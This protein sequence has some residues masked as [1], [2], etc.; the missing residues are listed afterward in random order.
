MDVLLAVWEGG[1]TIPPEMSIAARLV[2]RGHHVRV[3]G[4]PTVAQAATAA[5]AEHVAWTTAP[6]RTSM[7]PADDL[8][9]D[10]QIKSPLARFE[11]ALDVLYCGP[12][13]RY[14]A[15]VLAEVDRRRPDVALIDASLFG[16]MVAVEARGVPFSVLVPNIHV[17]PLPGVPPI[18]PGWQPAR[19]P[20]G[21][22]R[23]SIFAAISNGMWNRAVKPLNVLRARLGLSAVSSPWE[24]FD[25]ADA[26]HVLTARAFEFPAARLPANLRYVGPQLADPVWAEPWTSP[27]PA[28]DTRP[29]V[30]VGL[31]STYQAQTALLRRLVAVLSM[32]PV[33]ALVTLGPS[34]STSAVTSRSANV[35]VVASAPH[36]QIL[37]HASLAITHG[38]HGTTLKALAAGVPL[39]CIP[40]GR[41]QP[42]TAARVTA[43]GAGVRLPKTA[44]ERRL[45]RA[46]ERVL[47][48]PSIRAAARALAAA[49]AKESAGCDV[50]DE[51][52]RL[53]RPRRAPVEARLAPAAPPA[54]RS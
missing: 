34:L 32:L 1:G 21:R 44:S 23:D 54:S 15:D 53:V 19:G 22:A 39:V 43:R 37:P 38:G 42:D 9:K 33:R 20:F 50:I 45:R 48:D 25:R 27:W 11:R 10:W 35:V 26:V 6:R 47:G 49:I 16:A 4:D 7:D 5:G 3:L 51:I 8:L 14:A 13:G 36:E 24:L 30:L 12:A 28:G 18:G 29:L 40:M 46:I 17:A 41:D 2:A 31:S 52:E